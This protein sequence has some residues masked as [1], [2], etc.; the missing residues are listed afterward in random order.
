[1]RQAALAIVQH[2]FR[3]LLGNHPQQPRVFV[4]EADPGLLNCTWPH[5]GR[6]AVPLLCSDEVWSGLEYEVAGL[7]LF[8]GEPEV[9]LRLIEAVRRRYDGRKQNPWNHIECGDHYVR[10]MSAWALLEAATGYHFDAAQ[11]A[12]AFAPVLSA[13]R[14]R[15]PFFAA[16]GWG[17]YSQR[18]AGT[19][20]QACL[21]LAR[22]SLPLRRLRLPAAAPVTS[23]RARLAGRSV[24]L[25]WRSIGASV[26][27]LFE[28]G[29]TLS[30]AAALC[31]SLRLQAAQPADVVRK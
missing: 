29:L 27:L 1:V 9:A 23:A 25:E 4:T 14:F 7:L 21:C 13:A 20:L 2:N 11:A 24:G 12:L 8:E 28:P 6:P 3:H 17:T 19:R 18:L 30:P 22:G 26:D 16:A 5:G 31:L 10:A 15:G